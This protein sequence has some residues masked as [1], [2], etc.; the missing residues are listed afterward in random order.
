MKSWYGGTAI[1][2]L[3]PLSG[4]ARQF[5]SNRDRF[6]FLEWTSKS[7]PKPVIRGVAS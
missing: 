1:P 6:D 5:F 4:D 2:S 3:L 7:P